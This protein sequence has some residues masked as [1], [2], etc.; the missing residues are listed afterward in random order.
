MTTT[1]ETIKI[2][3]SHVRTWNGSARVVDMTNA[4]KRG[5]KCRQF[6][7]LTDWIENGETHRIIRVIK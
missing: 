5:K 2:A 6:M 1:C 3:P 4:G 7:F